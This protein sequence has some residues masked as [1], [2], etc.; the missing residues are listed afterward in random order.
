M[1]PLARPVAVLTL[2][3]T[4]CLL[5]S[6]VWSSA[7]IASRTV[8]GMA[9]AELQG[10]PAGASWA[11]EADPEDAEPPSPTRNVWA[12]ATCSLDDQISSERTRQLRPDRP[13]LLDPPV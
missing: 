2:V 5:F 13:P 11:E 8:L 10:P 9:S 3:A 7:T 4:V 6:A 12:R 1:A